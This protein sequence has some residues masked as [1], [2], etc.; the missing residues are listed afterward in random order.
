MSK[1]PKMYL[2]ITKGYWIG[3]FSG[4]EWEPLAEGSTTEHTV[5]QLE[6]LIL[7]SPQSIADL[8][9]RFLTKA[10]RVEAEESLFATYKPSF[11]SQQIPRKQCNNYKAS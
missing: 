11:Q 4:L 1:A 3:C 8:K 5:S 2:K 6:M 10:Q 7:K 9:I